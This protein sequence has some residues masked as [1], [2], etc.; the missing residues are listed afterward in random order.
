MFEILI[1][2]SQVL[3]TWLEEDYKVYFSCLT[4]PKI[5]SHNLFFALIC[6]ISHYVALGFDR[7]IENHHTSEV[8]ISCT[9][10]FVFSMVWVCVCV[11]VYYLQKFCLKVSTYYIHLLLYCRPILKWAREQNHESHRDFRTAKMEDTKFLDL[12]VQLG[13]PYLYQH[14]GNCEHIIIFTDIRWVTISSVSLT[15]A[16]Q[17]LA[18]CKLILA[19]LW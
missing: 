7:M 18:S 16:I 8:C 10:S 9:C 3:S 17:A 6:S 4:C 5:N 1:L 13:V 14:Q 19:M 11:C 15:S 2:I 12:N